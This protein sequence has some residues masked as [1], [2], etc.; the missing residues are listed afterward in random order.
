MDGE[1]RAAFFHLTPL[2]SQEKHLE[3]VQKQSE[4][5]TKYKK[6]ATLLQVCADMDKFMA[7]CKSFV[8]S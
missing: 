1:R 4:R 3:A 8:L 5:P 6:I 2:G 7:T